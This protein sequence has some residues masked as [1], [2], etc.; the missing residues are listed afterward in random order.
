MAQIYYVY[1]IP[2]RKQWGCTKNLDKRLKQLGYLESD[3]DRVIICGNIDIA[4]D[5]ERELNIEYGYGWN[6]GR[7]YRNI[8]KNQNAGGNNSLK[9]LSS[10][11]RHKTAKENGKKCFLSGNLDRARKKS[12][13]VKAKKIEVYEYKTGKYIATYP[14]ILQCRKEL[15]CCNIHAVLYGKY[16]HDKGY[17]FKIIN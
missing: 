17:T 1:H 4:A 12:A 15:K 14:T 2:K 13:L 5:M 6:I 16:N 11:I 8:I 7:D 3:L 9:K 10:I